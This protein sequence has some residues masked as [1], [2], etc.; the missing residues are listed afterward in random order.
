[1]VAKSDLQRVLGIGDR[2][3]VGLSKT[4]LKD[5]IEILKRSGIRGNKAEPI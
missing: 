2:P 1:M 4:A 3:T 5:S